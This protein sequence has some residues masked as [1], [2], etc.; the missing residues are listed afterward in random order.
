MMSP[1]NEDMYRLE[2]KKATVDHDFSRNVGKVK[3]A[4]V[5]LTGNDAE[6]YLNDG[7]HFLTV[8]LKVAQ[9]VVKVIH[10]HN[11]ETKDDLFKMDCNFCRNFSFIGNYILYDDHRRALGLSE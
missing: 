11:I 2:S 8:E 7:T 4:Y 1:G 10:S 5:V 9:S 3:S 6:L